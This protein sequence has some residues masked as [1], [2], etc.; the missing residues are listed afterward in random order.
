M[1]LQV[2][3]TPLDVEKQ[4]RKDLLAQNNGRLGAERE[5]R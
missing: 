1:S 4:S 3:S 2:F 5:N